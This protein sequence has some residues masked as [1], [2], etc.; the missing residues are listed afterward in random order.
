MSLRCWFSETAIHR[1]FSRQVFLKISQYS[2]ENTQPFFYRKPFFYRTPAVAAS[3]YPWLQILFFSWIW[4]LL[5]TDVLRNFVNFI[6]KHLCRS[7]A[8]IGLQASRP[9]AL[10]KKDSNTDIF[11]WNLQNF[12]EHLIWGLRTTASE[13]CSFT[14]TALFN[15]S[16]FWLKLIYML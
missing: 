10:L 6:G 8:L 5:L 1:Y 3:G 14:W 9:A 4:Y 16:H 13:I 7:L 12:S 11:L 15:K 2:Q